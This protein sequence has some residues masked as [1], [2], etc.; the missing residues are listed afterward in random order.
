MVDILVI[1]ATG[2]PT[3]PFS[4]HPTLTHIAGYTGQFIVKYLAHHPDRSQFSLA[5][6]GRSQSKL[7]D[8][9]RKLDLP[10][11]V[12]QLHVDIADQRSVDDAV[13]AATVVINAVGPYWTW[14][15]PVLGYV[16]A[17]SAQRSTGY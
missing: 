9:A 8:L 13:N 11:T 10:H 15:K 7:A 16:Y 5:I 14:G 6:A 12:Q 4:S 3:R 1:G 17:L 2:D